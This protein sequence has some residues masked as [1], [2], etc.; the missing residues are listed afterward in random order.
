MNRVTQA[1]TQS[2]FRALRIFTKKS[3]RRLLD[4][5]F[6]RNSVLQAVCN[7]SIARTTSIRVLGILMQGVHPVYERRTFKT[8]YFRDCVYRLKLN[9][10]L[11]VTLQRP[12][13]STTS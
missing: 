13:N 6:R 3:E 10:E 7:N 5:G 8:E 4:R 1:T 2:R 12:G 11:H 9:G